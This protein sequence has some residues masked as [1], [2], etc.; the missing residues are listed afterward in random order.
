MNVCKKNYFVRL[1]RHVQLAFLISGVVF[2]TFAG[3]DFTST[4]FIL[5]NPSTI[6]GGG[7]A[8]S[9]SFRY[10]GATGQLTGG[11]SSSTSFLQNSGFLYF[12]T[13]TS[14]VVS[15]TPGN[16]QV[17]LTWTSSLG[18]LANIT[19]YSVGISTVSGGSYSYTDVGNVLS[20]SNTGLT[21]GTTY[22]FK[23][24]SYAGGVLLS[25]SAEVSSTPSAPAVVPPTSGGGGSGGGG[26]GSSTT[27]SS[28]DNIPGKSSVVFSGRAYPL[29]KVTILKDG[30]IALSTIAGGDSNFSATL[31]KLAS[32]DYN[33]SVY[34]EDK[35]GLRSS[36]FTFHIFITAGVTTNVGGIFIA[37]TIS[38]DKSEVKRGDNISIFGQSTPSSKIVISVNSEQE[39]FENVQ[40]DANGVYLHNFDTSVLELGSHSTKS[41]ALKGSE[42]SA[43]GASVGFTVGSKNVILKNKEAIVDL[44][45]D[46]NQDNKLNLV[47]FS[48][49]SFWYG[50]KNP[51]AKVD[52]NHDGVVN[53]V[54]FSIMAF[55]WT[56]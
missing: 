27:E 46:T 15:A 50:K 19:T 6:V 52:L 45:G 47:D 29:S 55:Y 30:Q 34:G 43:F 24:R 31:S 39:H 2:F 49:A 42:I 44:K 23:I 21:N 10:F 5:E 56:G 16:G 26:G 7:E 18:I 9:S 3:A 32:G 11:E 13:A 48:V 40:S 28:N 22:F 20:R 53:I 33:F 4:N 41:K 36:P 37:P 1:K 38:V 8:N 12:P 51:P 25:E 35:D 17:S 54:D 14:P